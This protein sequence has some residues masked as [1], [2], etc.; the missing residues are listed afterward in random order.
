M[1]G[2]GSFARLELLCE[3]GNLCVIGHSCLVENPCMAKE[4]IYKSILYV[5]T[6][7]NEA[8]DRDS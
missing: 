1:A 4:D 8:E 6:L 2:G 5:L 7:K 3:A